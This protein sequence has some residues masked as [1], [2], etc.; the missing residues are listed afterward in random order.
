MVGV[1][2]IVFWET[3]HTDEI[4]IPRRLYCVE[5]WIVLEWLLPLPLVF[6]NSPKPLSSPS[7]L[8]KKK[9]VGLDLLHFKNSENGA[10]L[11]QLIT[12]II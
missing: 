7:L 12:I 9:S 6:I 4:P 8:I 2:I 5:S 1:I 10:F 11:K 3:L